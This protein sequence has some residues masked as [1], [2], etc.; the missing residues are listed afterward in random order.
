MKQFIL[1]L[2]IGSLCLGI[3]FLAE[4]TIYYVKVDGTGD[5]S[6][7]ENA[8][9]DL[10]A[11]IDAADLHD[12]IWIAEGTYYPTSCTICNEGDRDSSFL[13]SKRVRLY[14][15]FPS[16]ADCSTTSLEDRDWVNHPTI[17]SGDIG[18]QG[19]NTDNAYH[20]VRIN[21]LTGGYLLKFDGL[22]IRDGHA[23]G[24]EEIDK[25]GAGIHC[26]DGRFSVI[27]CVFE[28]N[29]AV[30]NG[31]AVYNDSNR[32]CYT[33]FCTFKDNTANNGAAIF[34]NSLFSNPSTD[35]SPVFNSHFVNNTATDKG[36]AIHMAPLMHIR[37]FG[38]LFHEN[39]AAVGGAIYIE[40][41]RGL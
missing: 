37:I 18:I 2:V 32:S 25:N 19:D 7:W 8:S 13:I 34:F 12:N 36:G 27:N 33:S 15:G 40:Q 6:S 41:P 9:G 11:I 3:P 39:Q 21:N 23:N 28:N 38:C 30:E 22:N 29:I 31:G 26:Q 17:L 1:L 24:N 35:Y 16:A 5:G 10:Q 20:V 14:G 4:A